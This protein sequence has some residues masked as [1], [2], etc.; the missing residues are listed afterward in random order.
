MRNAQP[1]FTLIEVLVTIVIVGILSAA[2]IPAYTDHV[3][4][5][6]TAEAF[7]ALGAAQANAEQFWSNTRSYADYHRSSAFPAATANFT[8]A[9]SNATASTYTITA[10]GR[11]KMAGFTYTID[12][13]GTRATTATPSWGT[14]TACWVDRKGGQCSS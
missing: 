14:N 12:Q 7:T 1:G 9:L 8:Y 5:S 13:N 3:I 6:R 10:T 2:A 11:A 4:R